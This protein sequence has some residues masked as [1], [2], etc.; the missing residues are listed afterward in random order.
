MVEGI[1]ICTYNKRDVILF[2]SYCKNQNVVLSNLYDKC[3]ID[4]QGLVFHSSEQLFFWQLL[5]G[6][7]EARTKVME[8]QT[9]KECKKIG[10]RYLKKMGWDDTQPQVQRAELQALRVAI[11]EKMRCCKE[12]RDFVLKSGD[13]KLVEYAWWDK[14]GEYG[15]YDVDPANK[16]SWYT[17][18]VVGQNIAGRLIMEWRKKWNNNENNI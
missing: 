11:G 10:S 9:A 13:K 16:Y 14:M 4:Y 17:G 12:F 15:C 18:Q 1:N 5:D 3:H 8:A 6:N 2:N 7:E